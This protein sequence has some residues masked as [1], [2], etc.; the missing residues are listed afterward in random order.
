MLLDVNDFT[1][2]EVYDSDEFDN[3]YTKNGVIRENETAIILTCKNAKS[4][5]PV[6]LRLYL[7]EL[8]TGILKRKLGSVK[9]ELKPPNLPKLKKKKPSSKPKD[10]KFKDYWRGEY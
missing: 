10:L 7:S 8:A 9:S 2:I 4:D 1:K 5:T 3:P 6:V